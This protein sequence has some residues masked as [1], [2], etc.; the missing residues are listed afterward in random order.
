MAV[1]AGGVWLWSFF[2]SPEEK[3][4]P[5]AHFAKSFITTDTAVELDVSSKSTDIAR[6]VLATKVKNELL[7]I[8]LIA[9]LDIYQTQ[10]DSE[11]LPQK[12]NFTAS[13]FLRTFGLLPPI[14][15]PRFLEE[16]FLFGLHSFKENSGFLMFKTTSFQSAFA[17]LLEWEKNMAGDLYLIL[18]GK[19]LR[20]QVRLGSFGDEIIKNIDT[21]V[22]RDADGQT[23]LIYSFLNSR[24]T[25]FITTNE[26]TFNEVLT[27]FQTPH[28]VVQ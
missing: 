1:A 25:I 24:D 27:R 13:Q 9:R 21:R 17:A 2:N 14:S 28:E 11:G 22:L 12:N 23:L 8:G 5:E 3:N 19:P 4:T 16:N 26:A 15:L 20:A 10:T 18:S 7:R 6:T